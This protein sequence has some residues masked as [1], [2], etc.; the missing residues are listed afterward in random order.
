MWKGIRN[1]FI[2]H[3]ARDDIR[4]D[5]FVDP[6]VSGVNYVYLVIRVVFFVKLFGPIIRV[7]IML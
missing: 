6:L 7:A 4:M 5:A 3:D 2:F 1:H